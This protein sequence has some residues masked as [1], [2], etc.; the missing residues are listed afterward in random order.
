MPPGER[1]CGLSRV[2]PWCQPPP[3]PRQPANLGLPAAPNGRFVAHCA[4]S[5]KSA[6]GVC[7][8]GRIHS[9]SRVHS[10]ERPS[11]TASAMLR[12]SEDCCGLRNKSTHAL[13]G[14]L[15][16]GM[17]EVFSHAA[18]EVFNRSVRKVGLQTSR[19]MPW[20]LRG[21][22]QGTPGAVK[23]TVPD[24]QSATGEKAT[25]G[26]RAEGRW[27]PGGVGGSSAPSDL[28]INHVTV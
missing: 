25:I 15:E 1:S 11:A 22:G 2:R 20:A 17:A 10:A 21:C 8:F 3:A 9:P 12:L 13:C 23:R 28:A 4:H 26:S 6:I 24:T 19:R 5:A 14:A 16:R 18:T 27:V 7:L